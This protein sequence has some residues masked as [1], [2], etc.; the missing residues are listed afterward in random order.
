MHLKIFISLYYALAVSQVLTLY[1]RISISNTHNKMIIYNNISI[2]T[3]Y[4]RFNK[5]V[6]TS[7]VGYTWLLS[8]GFNKL[9]NKF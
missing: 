3:S 8:K 9:I 1:Y 6:K 2:T 5:Y 7:I 4:I